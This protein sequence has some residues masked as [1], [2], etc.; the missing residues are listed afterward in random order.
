MQ[1]GTAPSLTVSETYNSLMEQRS[2]TATR[3]YRPW[4]VASR[5]PTPFQSRPS[6]DECLVRQ[7]TIRRAMRSGKTELVTNSDLLDIAKEMRPSTIEW[8]ATAN[9][10]VRY[11]NQSGLYYQVKEYIH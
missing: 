7:S 4:P 9:D 6:R 5:S 3:P 8:L 2:S 10:Y 11:N 1:T